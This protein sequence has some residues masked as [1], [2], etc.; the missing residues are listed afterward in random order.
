MT[1]KRREGLAAKTVGNHLSLPARDLPPRRQ[2]RLG[3]AT[4]RSH[5]VDRPRQHGPTPTSASSTRGARG[6]APRRARRPARAD[7]TRALPDRRD[8][9]AA[10]GRACSRCA[11]ATST[12]PPASSACGAAT[13]AASSARRRAGASSRAVPIADRVAA[14]LETPLRAP[15]RYQADDDL[16]FA[17]PRTGSPYDALEAA[18]ALQGGARRAPGVRAGPLPR[19]APHLRHADGRRRRAAARRS[20]SGWATATTGRRSIYA[21]YAPDP[22]RGAALANRAFAAAPN[23]S[24]IPPGPIWVAPSDPSPV[25]NES[26][27]RES[28]S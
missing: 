7:W 13:R 8:D 22:A 9:R 3:R 24:E 19:P 25:M 1:A 27:G 21:D 4:T 14:E 12:G 23:I 18:Q 2:A 10:P 20:R 6:A 15:H 17:T 5:A 26:S 16:V 28:D 11:G